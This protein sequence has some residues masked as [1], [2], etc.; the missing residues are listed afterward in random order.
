MPLLNLNKRLERSDKIYG[1]KKGSVKK[2]MIKIIAVLLII[3]ALIYFPIRGV[4]SS[5]KRMVAGARQMQEAV[6]NNDLNGIK[7][8]LA[9]VKAGDNSLNTSLTFLI[10]MR[11][12]PFIGGYYADAVHFS[13]AS[14]HPSLPSFPADVRWPGK[15]HHQLA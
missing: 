3:A 5:G 13:K 6:K 12:I 7:A 11:I 2:R 15:C 10:W 4:Y 14:S 1:K 8:G 9:E